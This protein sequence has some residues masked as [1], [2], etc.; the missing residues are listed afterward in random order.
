MLTCSHSRSDMSTHVR[1]LTN[2][3][4]FVVEKKLYKMEDFILQIDVTTFCS[5]IPYP[6]TRLFRSHTIG[7]QCAPSSCS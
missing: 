6:T 4:S 2:T 3:Y 1:A 5:P 7:V